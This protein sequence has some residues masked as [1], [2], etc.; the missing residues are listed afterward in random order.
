MPT[1]LKGFCTNLL[2]RIAP[3]QTGN[4][5]RSLQTRV[6]VVFPA[7]EA[8]CVC[9]GK[10]FP[11]RPFRHLPCPVLRTPAR[12]R[13][14]AGASI[15]FSCRGLGWRDEPEPLPQRGSQAVQTLTHSCLEQRRGRP[16]P[17]LLRGGWVAN[18]LR[19]RL[20]GCQASRGLGP[21]SRSSAG[22]RGPGRRGGRAA[23]SR[24]V[25]GRSFRGAEAG[26]RL[27]RLLISGAWAGRPLP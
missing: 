18:G 11:S 26:R 23:C 15:G 19:G 25:P 8:L 12:G 21:S 2:C 22:L 9:T 14:A 6:G 16:P 10:T 13:P 4:L 3:V 1:L 20:A 5:G 27:R 7:G 17:F 24:P